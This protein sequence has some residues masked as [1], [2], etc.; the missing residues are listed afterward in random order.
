MEP[1]TIRV[2]NKFNERKRSLLVFN[3][4]IGRDFTIPWPEGPRPEFMD[5][6]IPAEY[7][8]GEE[9]HLL[10]RV[11]PRHLGDGE[12]T[13][14]ANV[15]LPGKAGIQ[16]RN[17]EESALSITPSEKETIMELPEGPPNWQLKIKRP[18]PAGGDYAGEPTN[19][20]TLR[21]GVHDN[22]TVGD[23]GD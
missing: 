5:F 23:N 20:D 3:S 14:S 9:P 10:I 21:N 2:E 12:D 18:G 8:H 4:A 6:D 15:Y 22:V 13:I 7:P 16:F 1:F 19:S 11:A 17:L